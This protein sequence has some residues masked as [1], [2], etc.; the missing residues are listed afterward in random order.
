MSKDTLHDARRYEFFIVDNEVIDVYL[1]IIGGTAFAVYC[2]LIRM[3]KDGS[4]YP[5]HDLLAKKVGVS[6]PTVRNALNTISGKDD[7]LGVAGLAPLI[8]V[9]PRFDK[10]G[11]QTSNQYVIL[12]V[13]KESIRGG[14]K[15]V[16]PTRVS[17]S[18]N[19]QDTLKNKTETIVST[20]KKSDAN[21][22]AKQFVGAFYEALGVPVPTGSW[23]PYIRAAKTILE[24]GCTLDEVPQY[25]AFMNRLEWRKGPVTLQFASSSAVWEQYRMSRHAKPKASRPVL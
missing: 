16:Y 25:V 13:A 11:R 9:E 5:G 21:A 7:R 10:A 4:C 22:L 20:P 12:T 18:I 6:V 2:A 15:N 17:E 1:P 3:S 14:D 19:E 8:T 23:G 24:Y